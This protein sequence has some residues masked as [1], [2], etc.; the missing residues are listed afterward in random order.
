MNPELIKLDQTARK[1]GA[2][3]ERAAILTIVRK[4]QHSAKGGAVSASLALATVI[5]MI[6]ERGK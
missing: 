2:A 3:D 1:L 4:A 5:R 6:E